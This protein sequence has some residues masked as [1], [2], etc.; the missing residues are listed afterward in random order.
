MAAT[1]ERVTFDSHGQKLVGM[2]HIPSVAARTPAVIVTGSWTTIKEQMPANYAPLLAEAGLVALTFDF[3]GYGESEGQPRD[4]ESAVAKAEDIRA[5]VSFLQ[6]NAN[7][8]GERIGVLP[9]CASAGYTVLAAKDEPGIK[10]IAMIAPWLHNRPIVES[11][12]GGAAGVAERL[13][14]ARTARKRFNETGT[15]EYV[16]AASNSDTTAAMY[17]EGDALDYYLNPKRGARPQWGARFAVMAWKEWL[18]FDPIAMAPHVKVPTRLVTGEQTA[19]PGGAR[20]FASGMTA[21]HDIVSLDGTQFDFYDNPKT[22]AVAA[23]AAVEHFRSTLM[24]SSN[25]TD[26]ESIAATVVDVAHF[27]DHKQ[28]RELRD[29]YADTVQMDYTSLFGGEVQEQRG[30]ALIEAW[31]RLLT[32][33]VTQHLLGPI[34][35]EIN[36]ASATARCHVRGYHHA[37]GTPAGEDWMVAGHYVFHLGKDGSMWKIRA[38]KLE[39]F[40]QTG[41]TKLLEVAGGK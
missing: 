25:T 22:V 24:P 4:V 11:F 26:R 27:I 12:Y 40:Y 34:A 10:S 16:K 39:T 6:G 19:T 29:L 17:G 7:V 3:R 32:P 41:N 33:I 8:D 23:A 37:K 31:R 28:W 18:E 14:K 21:P 36:G 1:V 5:A 30:D 38:M 13:E 20:Q 35:V 15:V 2:L 9:I